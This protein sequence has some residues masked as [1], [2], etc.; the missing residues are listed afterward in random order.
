MA[1]KRISP[2]PV[3]EGGTGA[4]TLTDHGILVGSGTAAV[5]VLAV[6]TSG[7]V[8]VGSTGADPIMATISSSDSSITVTGGAGTLGLAT[9]AAGA[10]QRGGVI[11][12]SAAEAIAGT[13]ALKAITPSTLGSKLGTQTNHGVLVGA[14]TVAAVTAL[15]VGT[16]GMAL[17]ASTGADPVFVAL[18]SSDSSIAYTTGAGTLRK[19]VV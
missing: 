9:T 11:L 5:D 15:A 6:G 10:A 14:G 17:I 4:I 2:T 3:V 8:L 16:N 19:S 7:Q 18:G 13:D 1:Y 12:A